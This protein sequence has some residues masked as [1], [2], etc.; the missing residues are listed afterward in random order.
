MSYSDYLKKLQFGNVSESVDALKQHQLGSLTNPLDKQIIGLDSNITSL[1][2]DINSQNATDTDITTGL[3]SLGGTVEGIATMKKLYSKFKDF[4]DKASDLKDKLTGK[5]KEGD[6]GDEEA[7]GEAEG[8]TGGDEGGDFLSGIKDQVSGIKDQVSDQVSGLKDQVSDQVSE[9]QQ[10]VSGDGGA[11][12][13]APDGDIEMTEMNGDSDVVDGPSELNQVTDTPL[14]PTEINVPETELGSGTMTSTEP[15]GSASGDIEMQTFSSDAPDAEA[16]T[17]TGTG[18]MDTEMTTF[19]SNQPSSLGDV[20]S[21]PNFTEADTPTIAES[22]PNA[23]NELSSALDD[24]KGQVGDAQ[25]TLSSLTSKLGITAEEGAEGAEAATEAAT[26][27]AAD[28]TEVGLET[29]GGIADASGIGAIVGIGLQIAG[30]AVAIGT[31]VSDSTSNPTSDESELDADEQKE[32]SL[33][34]Q[35]LTDQAAV[36]KE[37]FTGANITPDMSSLTLQNVTSGSF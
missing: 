12:S 21:T 19:S 7:E 15:S 31:T 11:K 16:D 14:D 37:Q 30:A 22:D 29:A 6:E 2:G 9:L 24:V 27:A 18:S 35:E 4:K 13:D 36:A 3:G 33:K 26:D 34:N 17:F 20:G 32:D 8:E 10:R 1:T 23:G 5:K 25:D 28:A